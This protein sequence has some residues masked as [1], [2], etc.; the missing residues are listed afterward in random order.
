MSKPRLIKKEDITPEIKFSRKGR[1]NRKP[2]PSATQQ[3]VKTTS[4]WLQR[5]QERP[6]AREAF[7]ALF[8][9]PETQSA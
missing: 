2:A 1:K 3:V 8:T 9:E 5:R 6:S 7:A 4:E